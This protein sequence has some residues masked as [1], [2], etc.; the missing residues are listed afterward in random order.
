[1]GVAG[2]TL[3]LALA[4]AATRRLSLLLPALS[5]ARVDPVI[6]LRND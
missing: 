5:A 3:G 1:M 4:C 6:A 2:V